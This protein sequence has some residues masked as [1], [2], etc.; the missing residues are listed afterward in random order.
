[1]NYNNFKGSSNNTSKINTVL[2]W[3]E[4]QHKMNKKNNSLEL[5][6]NKFFTHK[7]KKTIF[8]DRFE[9]TLYIHLSQTQQ[10]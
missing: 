2:N 7:F 6:N 10:I 4:K 3:L 5:N 9:Q 1:M 8:S